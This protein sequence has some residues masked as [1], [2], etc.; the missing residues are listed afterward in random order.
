MTVLKI[1]LLSA[2]VGAVATFT[3]L[4]VTEARKP[5]WD[6]FKHRRGRQ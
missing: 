1:M 6:E 5:K 4:A 2:I 3:V